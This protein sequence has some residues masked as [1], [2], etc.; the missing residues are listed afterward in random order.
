MDKI[1]REAS[2]TARKFQL[3][4]RIEAMA[5]KPAYLTLRDHKE[6]FPP[7]LKFRLINHGL[8][9]WGRVGRPVLPL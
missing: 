4:D 9:G 3:D 5:I 7:R 6:D 8:H 2:T 1:N